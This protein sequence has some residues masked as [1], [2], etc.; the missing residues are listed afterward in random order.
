MISELI[1]SAM[2]SSSSSSSSATAAPWL[3]I[4]GPSKSLKTHFAFQ[5]ARE[6]AEKGQISLVITRRDKMQQ[7]PLPFSQDLESEAYWRQ[8]HLSSI[9]MFYPG[10]HSELKQMMASIQ[11]LRRRPALVIIEDLGD[12]VDP[13]RCTSRTDSTF[14]EVVSGLLAYIADSV[15]SIRASLVL[16]ETTREALFVH[17]LSRTCHAFIRKPS[18]TLK[19]K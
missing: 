18:K 1:S 9:D 5:L 10:S 12:I 8:S 3:C 2:A 13:L 16:T 11:C 6:T 7:F 14:H 15:R 19:I 17:E 4:V